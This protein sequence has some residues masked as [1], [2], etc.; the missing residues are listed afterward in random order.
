MS[1]EAIIK[2]EGLYKHFDLESNKVMALDGVDLDIHSTDFVIIYGPSG[3][4]KSTLL[5][6]ITG[7]ED[8]SKG[9]VEVRGENIYKLNDDKRAQFRADK[10]GVVSQM[11]HWVN[12]LNVWENVAIPLVLQGMTFSSS[13][14]RASL[15]LDEIGMTEHAKTNPS[16]LSGGQQQ[17]VSLA[18]A[19][20]RNP[21]IIIADEPT[22]NLDSH[23]ADEIMALFARLNKQSKRTIVMV[24]HNLVY[25][26]Y[27]NHEVAMK[28]GKVESKSR[29]EII[30]EVEREVA[31][32]ANK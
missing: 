21:W 9:S 30:E 12:A 18:R 20:I 23:S 32:S 25:L 14:K 26:P 2:I 22:G 19:L 7:L 6:V 1:K 29:A 13:K 16:K 27:S 5:N 15:V 10:F 24:T 3:C 4:G 28:D 8:P 11:P 17:K 31:T